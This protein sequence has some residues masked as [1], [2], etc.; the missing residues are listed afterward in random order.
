MAIILSI[1]KG[2]TRW[3][4]N[5]KGLWYERGL[6]KSGENLGASSL[7]ETYRFKPLL[8]KQISLD[9]PFKAITLFFSTDSGHIILFS[10]P[11][12]FFA[13][14]QYCINTGIYLFFCKKKQSRLGILSMKKTLK[15][16]EGGSL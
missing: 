14:L 13:H 11:Q 9:S 4:G 12:D 16:R 5:L 1:P 6:L 7:R 3:R 2:S 8:A 10:G 15:K